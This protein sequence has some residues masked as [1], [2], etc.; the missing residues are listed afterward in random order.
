MGLVGIVLLLVALQSGI[1]ASILQAAIVQ[2]TDASESTTSSVR[3][4][5]GTRI[6]APAAAAKP[7]LLSCSSLDVSR[8]KYVKNR[9]LVPKEQLGGCH[10]SMASGEGSSRKT[11]TV[12]RVKQDTEAYGLSPLV[13][14]SR[15]N[16]APEV[17]HGYSIPGRTMWVW[18]AEGVPLKG[19]S[20]TVK[21]TRHTEVG[22]EYQ[23]LGLTHKQG[24]ALALSI[25]RTV[26]TLPVIR[27]APAP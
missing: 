8:L 18:V 12:L 10:W 3:S 9:K 19:A 20:K 27:T 13:K 22:L 5:G 23:A 14:R 15:E 25:S 21:A 1:A 2:V 24:K 11:I 6:V 4:A 26:S 17:Y 7:A 16:K